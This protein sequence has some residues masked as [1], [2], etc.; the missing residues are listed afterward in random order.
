MYE[1]SVPGSGC[2]EGESGRMN[3][4]GDRLHSVE[5]T[6]DAKLVRNL[7]KHRRIPMF[8]AQLILPSSPG[9]RIDGTE[10]SAKAVARPLACGLLVSLFSSGEDTC[11]GHY[12]Q[13]NL[14]L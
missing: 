4:S 12:L 10:D 7:A 9:K 5:C 3:Y 1:S 8:P 13:L 6:A 2:G 14:G 11:R